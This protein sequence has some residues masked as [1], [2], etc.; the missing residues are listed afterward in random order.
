[1]YMPLVSVV[2]NGRKPYGVKKV[3]TLFCLIKNENCSSALPCILQIW[4]NSCHRSWLS[5]TSPSYVHCNVVSH[6][7]KYEEVPRTSFFEFLT[8]PAVQETLA[9]WADNW[10]QETYEKNSQRRTIF[11]TSLSGFS[12]ASI[13]WLDARIWE[14][15][16]NSKSISITSSSM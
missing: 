15:T 3:C 16:C 1:M 13:T 14:H 12:Y 2:I 8:A 4:R 7:T 6:L 5:S 11:T 9:N 10:N